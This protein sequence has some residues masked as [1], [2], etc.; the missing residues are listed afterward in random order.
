MPFSSDQKNWRTPRP[1]PS[2]IFPQCHRIKILRYPFYSSQSK[3]LVTMSLGTIHSPRVP[4]GGGCN[5][6]QC[7][8]IVT[9]FGKFTEVFRGIFLVWG[10]G[11]ENQRGVMWEDHSMK[12]FIMGKENFNEGGAGFSSNIKKKNNEKINMKSFFN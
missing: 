9:V 10:W 12:E 11:G 8:H 1:P 4:V 3:N 2:H 6:D 5:F 7:L